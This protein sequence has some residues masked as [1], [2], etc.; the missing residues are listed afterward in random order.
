M[1]DFEGI[2]AAKVN[3]GGNYVLP[4]VYPLLFVNA[5][6]KIVSQNTRDTLVVAE[7]DILESRVD[8]RKVGSSMSWIVNLKH[9]PALGNL[10][11]FLASVMDVDPEMVDSK[12]ADYAVS[13]ENPLRG[14]LVKCEAIGI[15]TKNKGQPFTKANWSVVDKETQTTAAERHKAA[16]FTTF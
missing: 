6:K 10:K 5:V 7:L 12:G 15:T 2:G 1:S 14:R 16:G 4:G 11:G 3:Q 8:D 13:P 9:Q